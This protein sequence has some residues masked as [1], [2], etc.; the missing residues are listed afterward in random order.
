MRTLFRVGL[1]VTLLLG[2]GATTSVAMA[3]WIALLR[4]PND[5]Y[6]T[7][8]RAGGWAGGIEATRGEWWCDLYAENHQFWNQDS[9]PEFSIEQHL[10][11]PGWLEIRPPVNDVSHLR[12]YASG[13]PALCLWADMRVDQSKGF[14]EFVDNRLLMISFDLESTEH[15]AILGMETRGVLPGRNPLDF[16][17]GELLDARIL[18]MSPRWSGLAINTVV[19]TMLWLLLLSP[20]T[21]LSLFLARRRRLR[22]RCI[23]CGYKLIKEVSRCSE[24]GRERR[25]RPLLVSPVLNRIAAAA[26]TCLLTAL[27]SFVVV[28]RMD[29]PYRAA[30]VAA[31]ENDLARLQRLVAGGESVDE[32]I[33]DKL[34]GRGMAPIHVAASENHGKIVRWLMTQ[35]ADLNRE[36]GQYM[37]VV[38]HVISVGD[39][40]LL[41]ELLAA[42][43]DINAG[44][45]FSPLAYACS[46][47]EEFI[48]IL[49]DAGAEINPEE[50]SVTPLHM[51]LLNDIDRARQFLDMGA[52]IGFLEI[53]VATRD[54][55]IEALKLLVEYGADLNLTIE[56]SLPDSSFFADART[57]LWFTVDQEPESLPVW[58]YLIEHNVELN[59]VD[60]RGL[61]TLMDAVDKK[62][63]E[64]TRFL[65]E[66]GANPTYRIK[67]SNKSVVDFTDNNEM[68]TLLNN[69]VI[70]WNSEHDQ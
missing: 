44:E 45:A 6:L 35:G 53:S 12:A 70:C 67:G 50:A 41:R 36:D 1:F 63:L 52:H 17:N 48:D 2:L 19:N 9:L 64:F 4:S 13:W 61:S 46:E 40:N 54:H 34:P 23:F 26:F 24:C 16:N 7:P 15:A 57:N 30:Q 14:T 33:A 25:A 39:A 32:P 56:S 55:T 42:G 21:G 31:Y 65:I 59:V 28:F 8:V 3:W 20:V 18:P 58:E 47:R 49:L 37:T 51:I 22:D 10:S 29:P 5:G 11:I 66:H 68:I 60:Y 43:A 27:V 62:S 38:H 69:A